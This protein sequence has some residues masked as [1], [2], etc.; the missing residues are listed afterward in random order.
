MSFSYQNLSVV[1]RRC[2]R[3]YTYRWRKLFT[4]SSSSTEP[5]GQFQPNLAK[6][7]L[8]WWRNEEP[9]PF[10][11][12]NN[13]KIAKIHWRNL[14]FFSGIAGTISTKLST[15]HPWVKGIQEHS[16]EGPSPFPRVD[17]YEIAKIY[18]RYIKKISFSRTTDPI[19]TKLGT[20]H[21]W[22]KESHVCS[23]EDLRAFPRGNKFEVVKLYWRN[24]KIFSR[25][26]WS[27]LANFGTKHPWV[28]GI[29]V[30]SNEETFYSHKVDNGIFFS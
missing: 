2:R 26:T 7:I 25:T 14:I 9:R 1:R 23:N 4:F 15:M 27:I 24:F 17:N 16:N 21:P 11:R 8:G 22:V 19:S 5:L 18:R 20:K 30:Y 3:C 29:Q 28:K 12:G 6:S 13:Y 10:S